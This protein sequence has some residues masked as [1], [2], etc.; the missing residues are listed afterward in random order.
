MSNFDSTQHPR[1]AAGTTKGGQFTPK[2]NS[3]PEVDLSALIIE[4]GSMSDRAALA[5][6]ILPEE[7]RREL[8]SLQRVIDEAYRRMAVA[9]RERAEAGARILF[10]E[11]ERRYPGTEHIHIEAQ[12]SWDSGGEWTHHITA[13]TDHDGTVLANLSPTNPDL[14]RELAHELMYRANNM[15]G[16]DPQAYEH[17]VE[18][19]SSQY[20]QDHELDITRLIIHKSALR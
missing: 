11:I 12:H 18:E 1:N 16:G 5:A 4:Y 7:D 20:D 15:L 2:P 9:N 13:I 17:I 19:V 10:N 6:T 8:T 14:D 3:E